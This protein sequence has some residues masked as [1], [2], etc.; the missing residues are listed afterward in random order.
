[1]V[2]LRCGVGR[3]HWER[4]AH[5]GRNTVA[6]E[7]FVLTGRKGKKKRSRNESG[8]VACGLGTREWALARPLFYLY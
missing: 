6:K 7:T 5:A 3:A 8:W 4:G 2:L 1:M